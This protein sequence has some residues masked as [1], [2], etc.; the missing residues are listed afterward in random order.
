MRVSPDGMIEQASEDLEAVGEEVEELERELSR[1]RGKRAQLRGEPEMTPEEKAKAI[2]RTMT[3]CAKAL[4]NGDISLEVF[5]GVAA[6]ARGIYPT[7][8]T[9]AKSVGSHAHMSI[10]QRST[11]QNLS[12]NGLG[13]LVGA[14]GSWR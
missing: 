12:G 1:K 14:D 5:A 13:H 10:N 3:K 2:R 6:M 4:S 7:A 9:F 11:L 8:G